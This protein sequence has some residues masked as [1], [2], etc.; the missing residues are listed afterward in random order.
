MYLLPKVNRMMVAPLQKCH[1]NCV[2]GMLEGGISMCNE[3]GSRLEMWYENI[4]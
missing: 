3:F 1:I 4:I 2:G